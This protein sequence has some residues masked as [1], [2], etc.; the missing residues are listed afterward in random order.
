MSRSQT[1]R[2]IPES[3]VPEQLPM[4]TYYF[5]V[6]PFSNDEIDVTKYLEEQN[7]YPPRQ[8]AL[9]TQT[10]LFIPRPDT[11]EYVPAKVGVDTGTQVE[12]V[13]EL[14]DFDV[15]VTPIL[16]VI[17]RKTIDQALFELGC[18]DELSNLDQAAKH[19][20]AEKFEANEWMRIRE[21]Q[22]IKENLERRER[23]EAL[24]QA[25]EHENETRTVIAGLQ[26]MKQILPDAVDEIVEGLF[27]A[28]VWK[29][30]D[31][32][33]VEQDVMPH[34]LI[35]SQ[36]CVE[37]HS[38]AREVLDEIL[39]AAEP[40]YQSFP[41]YY[42]PNETR[43]I[44]VILTFRRP[45]ADA[46]AA[47]EDSAPADGDASAAGAD[48][49]ITIM[50]V[51]VSKTDSLHTLNKRIRAEVY[52]LKKL[53]A[54]NAAGVEGEEV[55]AAAEAASP[56]IAANTVLPDSAAL[57]NLHTL[58]YETFARSLLT[59][60]EIVKGTKLRDIAVDGALWNFPFPE[61]LKLEIIVQV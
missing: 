18:E 21:D 12:D 42:E 31:I 54:N 59:Q 44:S 48:K 52:R 9:D 56:V 49:D 3:P 5:A 38:S 60:D 57:E 53:A 13:R 24:Q 27:K 35:A 4:S 2:K 39:L 36:N 46:D 28:A 7:E 11:P 17:V 1:I 50:T 22:A 33:G 16:E 47:G 61:E 37:A 41:S 29:R 15:E 25:R 43:K 30:M 58:L 20:R 8:R 19:F 10:D 23:I 40:L 6:K 14:F 45:A 51:Q 34:A 26:M 55:E 32:A